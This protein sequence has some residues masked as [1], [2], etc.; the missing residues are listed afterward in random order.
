MGALLRKKSK[1]QSMSGVRRQ[2]DEMSLQ[3]TSMADIFTIILVF[4]LK[5]FASGSL[6]ITPT[7]GM[8]LPTAGVE[9]TPVEALKIEVSEKAIQIEGRPVVVLENFRLK[10]DDVGAQGGSRS[11]ASE[12]EKERKRQVAIAQSNTDVKLDPKVVVVAD[13]RVPYSTIK[14]VLAAAAIHGYTDFKLAVVNQNQ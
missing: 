5:S 13:K 7:A 8:Q 6:N 11:L 2:S 14:S 9:G 12:L 4:L 10:K 3:I 1:L